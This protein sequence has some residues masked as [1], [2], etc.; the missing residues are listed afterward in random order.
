MRKTNLCSEE[1]N[2]LFLIAPSVILIMLVI[3]IPVVYTFYCSFS[4]K[5]LVFHINQF[6]GF[7]NYKFLLQD[8]RFWHS[9]YNN[10]Y[11][12]SIAVIIELFLGL[13]IALLLN[14]KFR[15][16]TLVRAAILVPWIM[17]TVIVAKFWG[18]V[19]TFLFSYI[20][21]L[22]LDL[23]IVNINLNWREIPFLAMSFAI[24]VDVWKYTP[25]MVLILLTGLQ[26][27]PE[28]QYQAALVDG[29]NK[30]QRFINVTIPFILPNITVALLLRT[31]DS[32]SSFSIIYVLINGGPANSNEIMPIYLFKMLFQNLQ[33]GYGSAIAVILFICIL[34]ISSV[35]FIFL[36][37]RSKGENR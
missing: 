21:T 16:R 37:H 17:P 12:S 13:G 32:F 33:F 14:L 28:E 23:N 20:N 2:A 1:K 35:Y 30:F 3:L 24:L 29:A 15:A 25:F 5:M 4:N 11:F 31:I 6:I 27:I 7:D 36:N 19:Y 26:V 8:D 34:I 9:F 10:I 18:I 22:L